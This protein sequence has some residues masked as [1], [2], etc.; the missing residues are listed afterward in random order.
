MGELSGIQ[1]PLPMEII[2]VRIYL[3]GPTFDNHA[4]NRV[5][6]PHAALGNTL[7]GPTF[8]ALGNKRVGHTLA[9]HGNTRVGPTYTTMEI[10][11]WAPL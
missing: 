4:N 1:I 5:G 7:V 2:Y 8:A 11:G 3:V 10:L 6:P 9:C